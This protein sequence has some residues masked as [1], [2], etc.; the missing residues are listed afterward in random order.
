MQRPTVSPAKSDGRGDAGNC[1][2]DDERVLDFSFPVCHSRP[3]SRRNLILA[4]GEDVLAEEGATQDGAMRTFSRLPVHSLPSF[5]TF[6]LESC[7][8]LLSRISS[9]LPTVSQ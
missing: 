8:E 9:L 4:R 1:D 2:Y 3:C 6:E 7:R 5:C